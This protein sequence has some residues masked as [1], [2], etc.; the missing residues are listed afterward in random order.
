MG[1]WRRGWSQALTERVPD[2]SAASMFINEAIQTAPTA[3]PILH[4]ASV[5]YMPRC[6]TRVADNLGPNAAFFLMITA[7][8]DF[9]F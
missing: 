4:Q 9:F 8:I 6:C 2:L 1:K 5:R 3:L 7:E